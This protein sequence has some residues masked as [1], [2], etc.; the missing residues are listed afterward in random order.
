M[1]MKI[2]NTSTNLFLNFIKIII[3]F[4]FL[5]SFILNNYYNKQINNINL[6]F[7]ENNID[8]SKFVTDIKAIAIYLPNFYSI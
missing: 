7:Y 4:L 3:L 6:L 1:I 5:G 2:K 8:F